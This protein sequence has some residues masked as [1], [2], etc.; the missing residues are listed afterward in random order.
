M[1]ITFDPTINLWRDAD[2][3]LTGA[4]QKDAQD[5]VARQG[6]GIIS[7]KSRSF[8]PLTRAYGSFSLTKRSGSD[9][10]PNPNLDRRYGGSQ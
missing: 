6:D 1:A 10:T 3:G 7:A 2:T 4:T 9:M 8:A 5:A